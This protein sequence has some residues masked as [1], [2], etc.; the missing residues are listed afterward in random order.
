MS[1]EPIPLEAAVSRLQDDQAILHRDVEGRE[2]REPSAA[3]DLEKELQDAA[4]FEEGGV[5]GW[6]A[7]AGA[8]LILLCTFGCT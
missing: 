1:I 5:R 2:K 6:C 3:G 8:F 7:V 4:P